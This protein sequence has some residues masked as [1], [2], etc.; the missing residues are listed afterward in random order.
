MA[1]QVAEILLESF[2]QWRDRRQKELFLLYRRQAH[3]V[4]TAGDMSSR[5]VGV[6]DDGVALG[7]EVVEGANDGCGVSCAV[8]VQF[9]SLTQMRV[10]RAP[11]AAHRL[12]AAGDELLPAH[13][14]LIEDGGSELN[15]SG[16]L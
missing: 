13:G 8:S 6:G 15:T 5:A 7:A 12:E 11:I 1:I 2:A 14:E 3:A 9:Y 4:V 16:W 10:V